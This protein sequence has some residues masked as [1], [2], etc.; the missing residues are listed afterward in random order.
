MGLTGLIATIVAAWIADP[1]DRWSDDL[2]F[3][4]AKARVQLIAVGILGG[5]LTYA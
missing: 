3:E 2:W 4:V 5:A 1:A